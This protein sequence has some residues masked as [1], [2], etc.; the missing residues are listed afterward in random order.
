MENEAQP[1]PTDECPPPKAG[2]RP[3]PPDLVVQLQK[4]YP[5]LDYTMCET[6]LMQSEEQLTAFIGD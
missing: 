1:P 5:R 3:V 6:L 2:K 4:A